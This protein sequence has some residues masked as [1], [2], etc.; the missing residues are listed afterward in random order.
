MRYFKGKS[1]GTL[2]Y[3]ILNEIIQSDDAQNVL[4]GK[5]CK[6]IFLTTQNLS[7]FKKKNLVIKF[8]L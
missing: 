1:Q 4:V 3:I 7:K 2:S 8:L 6:S 5:F